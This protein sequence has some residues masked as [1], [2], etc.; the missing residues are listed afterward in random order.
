MNQQNIIN[1]E[2]EKVYESEKSISYVTT[3]SCLDS[4]HRVLIDITK[5]K[6]ENYKP[7]FSLFFQVSKYLYNDN[8]LIHFWNRIKTAFKILLFCDV[9]FEDEFIFRGEEQ[10]KAVINALNNNLYKK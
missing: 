8:F 2:L 3:C 4:N 1:N 7:T 10:V 6:N 5:Y 9:L